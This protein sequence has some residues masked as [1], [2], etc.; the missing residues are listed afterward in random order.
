MIYDQD[1]FNEALKD[2]V[3]NTKSVGSKIG[4]GMKDFAKRVNEK[5]V[6]LLNHQI[7]VK[8]KNWKDEVG[9]RNIV[10]LNISYGHTD[11]HQIDQWL[12]DVWDVDKDA[13]RIY[14]LMDIIEFIKEV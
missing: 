11:F 8:Y 2:V 6:E 12:L 1:K 13:Q 4:E 10:P 5:N 14:A 9:I 7:K 3:K